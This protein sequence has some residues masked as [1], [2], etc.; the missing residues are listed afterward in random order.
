M[1]FVVRYLLNEKENFFSKFLYPTNTNLVGFQDADGNV[2]AGDNVNPLNL[3]GTASN[4][5]Y[6]KALFD[7]FSKDDI[8]RST[9]FFDVYKIEG[10]DAA[11][12]LTKFMGEMDNDTRRFTNDWPIYRYADLQLLLAEIV[13]MQGGDPTTYINSIRQRAYG[14]TYAN[15]KYPQSGETAE[16]AILEERTKEFVGEGK[17]WYDI[18]RMKD[19]D[20]AKALQINV[21]GDLVE[22]HLLWPIDAAVMSKDPQVE[23]TPGY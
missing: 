18:R 20:L 8:R 6:T 2:Y 7:E 16:D 22:K 17:H 14:D 13:T 12:L 19:G 5:Q 21:T 11:I 9:T 1:I 23:Q 15:H 4:F 10:G 3:N